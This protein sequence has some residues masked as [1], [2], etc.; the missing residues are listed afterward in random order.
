M[1]N[2]TSPLVTGSVTAALS[3]GEEIEILRDSTVIGTAT[4]SNTEWSYQDSSLV[5][6]QTY[7]YTARV[8]DS[9]GNVSMES[10][11]VAITVDT[12]AP[13][14][15]TIL[16]MSNDTGTPGDFISAANT[17]IISGRADPNT[18]IEIFR[19][20]ESIGTA[21]VDSTGVWQSD[22]IN[23]GNLSNGA[24]VTIKARSYDAA[25]N[26]SEEASQL[27][28]KTA[29]PT[30]SNIDTS[31]ISPASGLVIQGSN[32]ES[33]LGY[34]V[35]AAGDLNGDGI[36]D[37]VVGA[38]AYS[39]YAGETYV[40][41]G[42]SSGLGTIDGSDRSVIDVSELSSSQG[43][44]IVGDQYYSMFGSSVSSAGDINHDGI[45]DLIIGAYGTVVG[46]NSS[47]GEVYVVF[48]S[49]DG[50]GIDDGHG[51]KLVDLSG[52]T[53]EYGFI[54]QGADANAFVGQ[55][56]S[57]AG[58]V[59]GDGID[60][61]I[62][63]ASNASYVVFGSE[64]LIG[65]ND[66]HDRM[67]LN[68]NDL[69]EG[70]GFILRSFHNGDNFGASVSSIGDFN[71]DGFDDIIVGASTGDD[72]GP[73]AG[74]AY[75]IYGSSSGVGTNDGNGHMVF[76]AS[77][78]L[79]FGFVILGDEEGDALGS[80]VSSAGDINGDGIDDLL[81]GAYHGGDGAD[82][83]GQ[84]YV[85]FGNR[86][87]FDR[88]S[89]NGRTQLDTAYL[90][91]SDGFVIQNAK[92][93]ANF[94]ISVS[95]AGDINGD[96]IGD[97]L[98]GAAFSDADGNDSGAAYVIFGTT[99]GFGTNVDGRKV[100]NLS[101]LSATEGFKIQ[102]DSESDNLGYS[103]AAAGDVN[104]DG[105]AD[106]IVGSP[107]GDDGH[108]DAGEAYIIYGQGTTMTGRV[109]IGTNA[110]DFIAGTDL[111]DSLSGAGGA[112]VLLGYDGDD[113]LTISDTNFRRI[114]G[115]DGQD[116]LIL[117]GTGLHLN[118][119]NIASDVVT[120]I[121]TIDITG[122]GANT[123]SFTK[124]DVLDLSST[125]NILTINGSSDDIVNADGF[126]DSN[127]D[128]VVGDISYNIYTNGTA[129]LRIDHEIA[130]V[131]TVLV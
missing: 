77:D 37:V 52:L 29:L 58:D 122:T 87:I 25:G 38:P 92:S 83:A 60:D 82:L 78:P 31:T 71:G 53:S 103:V 68:V 95:S 50:F 93:S 105:Y 89:S 76:D 66:G 63:G 45:A 16:Q 116:T 13:S 98:V 51:H 56:V 23:L 59:N 67:I 62:I 57:A 9:A 39:D 1:T 75:V 43:F 123:I 32:G 86:N 113:T 90:T 99:T 55:S 22:D 108:A 104:G 119:A 5:D 115:G 126:V 26:S 54:I 88:P 46:S 10:A 33:L 15:P 131:M 117:S 110:V 96:G 41:F 94:G 69:T 19:D 97:L 6:G 36:D 102:G 73:G 81:V 127:I 121:E 84:A 65:T 2:D 12:A 21:T 80:S 28:T 17:T 14:T 42:S 91:A 70:K 48:G 18:T 130:S 101:N 24:S 11:V 7:S 118:F 30:F 129:T 107:Y 20:L 109:A 4:I 44:R 79:A 35:H 34:S 85:I 128:Q 8:R 3:T 125:T 61:I 64:T 106:L 124:Q 114:D 120:N 100:V 49:T 112:D 74:E 72:G 47:A 27:I 111:S 40:V